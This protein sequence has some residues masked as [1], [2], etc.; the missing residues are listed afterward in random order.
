VLQHFLAATAT[1][2]LPSRIRVDHG[3]ENNA[4][5]SVMELIRG[6]NRG[7]AL[8][9]T[10]VHNQRIERSWL[11]MWHGATHVFYMLFY[12]LEEQGFLQ[13]DSEAHMWAL[14]FVFIPRLNRA[15]SAFVD[16]WNHHGLRTENYQSPLQLFVSR[17]LELMNSNLT[18]TRDLF[19]VAESSDTLL[20]PTGDSDTTAS[21]ALTMDMEHAVTVPA[22]TCPLSE[23]HVAE[24]RTTVDPLDDTEDELGVTVYRRTVDFIQQHIP[25]Q[26]E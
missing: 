5:C 3:G 24:L 8:R 21:S 6:S 25:S 18:A 14:H 15:L 13:I 2:C 4:I 7:S 1:Y 11:D 26:P 22:T 20:H 16:Q 9:G 10:S 23:E 19:P 12:F 17:S